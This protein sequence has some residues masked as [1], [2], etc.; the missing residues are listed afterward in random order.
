MNLVLGLGR[1]THGKIIICM[2][3]CKTNVHQ[4]QLVDVTLSLVK[5]GPDKA[6][7]VASLAELGPHQALNLIK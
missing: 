4:Y 1:V 2:Q 7:V 5:L 6:D 3:I